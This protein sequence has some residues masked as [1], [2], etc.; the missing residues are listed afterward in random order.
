MLKRT[1]LFLFLSFTISGVF[2]QSGTL[3]GKILDKDNNNEP[4]PFANI[5]IL[6]N[7][8]VITGGMTDFDGKYTIKPIPAGV[9]DVKASYVGYQAKMIKGLRITAG[10]I[11]FQDFKLSAASE[12]LKEVEV[13]DYKVPL[14]SKDQTES[15]GTVT[16]EEISKMP[17][18]SAESVAS[19]VGGVYSED[20][21]VA[22]IRGSRSDATVYY[23]D[24]MKVRGTN[25]VPKSALEQVTVIT[26]G[27]PAKYG[28]ATGGVIS[29]TT[30]GPQK[31]MFGGAEFVTSHFLDNY[32][33][34]LGE[35]YLSGPMFSKK[36]KD[37]NDSTKTIKE[38]I[39]GYFVSANGMYFEDPNTSPLGY[40]KANDGVR[41]AYLN[42]PYTFGNNN[43]EGVGGFITTPTA[44]FYR[45]DDFHKIYTAENSAQ[46]RF[47]AQGKVDIKPSKAIN[48]TI[49]GTYDY[50]NQ[51]LFS[52]SNTAFNSSNNGQQIYSNWRVYGRLTHKLGN[53][54]YGKEED[55]KSASL[56]KNVYYTLQVDYNKIN[57]KRQDYN[58]QDDLFAYGHNGYYKTYKIKTYEFTDT[59]SGY[60]QG[61]WM[62][63]GFMDTLVTF[64]P[65]ED[66][67][68]VGKYTDYVY[69]LADEN[70]ADFIYMNKTFLEQFG[71]IMNGYSPNSV[72]GMWAS[73]GTVYNSYVKSDNQQ[74][75][76]TGAGYADVGDHEL[77]IGF[78]FEQRNDAYYGVS[79]R[80][81]W[82]LAEQNLNRHIEQLDLSN[83]IYSN[84]T[85][86]YNRLYNKQ[87]QSEFDI[88]FRN[89]L[90]DAGEYIDGK[91]VTATGTQWID[92]DTYRSDQ[93]KIDYFSPDELLNDGN[94]YVSY[95]GYDAHGNRISGNPTLYDFF[96][97][98]YTDALGNQRYKR[99]IAAFKPNYAAFY[100]QDKF[101]FNDLIFNIGLRVDRYDANQMVLKDMYL[102]HDAKTVGDIIN[103]GYVSRSE[104]PSAI[105]DDYIVYVNDFND[106]HSVSDIKG[107]RSGKNP[108]EVAWFDA[109]GNQIT[110]YKKIES[111]TG[112]APLLKDPGALNENRNVNYNAF[113]DYDPQYTWMP[114]ISFSF[115]ISDEALFFAH[116]DVLSQRPG[117]NNLD[118]LAYM[119]IDKQGN[120][121]I[122]NPNLRP[123]RT[124]D[125][126]VGFQQKLTN[127]SSLKLSGFYKEMR[128]MIQ[129]QKIAG[130]YPADYMTYT[131]I[132]FGTVKGITITY[133][134]RRTGNVSMKLS[135]TLQFANGTGS[136][137]ETGKA[138][139][140]TDQP[141]LRTT[142]P[143][144]FD[145][146]HAIQGVFDYRFG[147]GK[148]YNGPRWFGMDFFQNTGANFVFNFGTGTPYSRR[149]PNTNYLI[150][151]LNGS[152]KPS[153]FTVDLRLD[154]DI[155]LTFGKDDNKK[156]ANLNVYLQINN[157]FNTLNIR[158]VYSTTGNADDDGYL[159]AAKNQPV[160]N[161]QYDPQ[162]Y[163]DYYNMMLDSRYWM[164]YSPRT[165][166][167]GVL[168]N[169]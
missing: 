21:Q 10:K 74:F 108:S 129:T 142:M 9:Y 136:N 80:G 98:T 111:G 31:N 54:E 68:E 42:E 33:Y 106:F 26:G 128:D 75:R 140:Q 107:F 13:V 6:Q 49:G 28:D 64:K 38:P 127:S 168:F 167:L 162:S 123:S 43:G 58:H 144:D 35:A 104:I 14:I 71:A 149:D 100:I 52:L 73:P 119:Y 117:G 103:E 25:A 15:G 62:Q 122:N 12:I 169:F 155:P 2:A 141:N 143:L 131:N 158:N 126:E 5:S 90:H 163:R 88:N 27:L 115:P 44:D 7:G 150:G 39:V 147:S 159:T 92:L 109:N 55:E 93:L 79:P 18:R 112:L 66:N 59:L 82:V 4:I 161:S 118:P 24:G 152:R 30:K 110:D 78:E 16:S 17:G 130:A 157:L 86:R 69:R 133:D 156:H 102:L 72:Y 1:L 29:I 47:T 87:V 96:Y 132:D 125:Y 99:E 113:V 36:K 51:R 60:P 37:P 139:A 137:A 164:Y 166:R 65:T 124:I 160:I 153:T 61:V 63:N 57:N 77:Q 95:R 165:I 134:L 135:Y 121:V 41:D 50:A 114:R 85:V 81:L 19:T 11:T 8:K 146:R 67:P 32:N 45:K 20:G 116:Y 40:Y 120:N 154:K 48:V 148:M 53:N 34:N 145:R 76:F 22:S 46:K 56:F 89:A 3:K 91:L 23:I 101:A 151:S 94:S 138:L 105:G 84:D 83:P 70:N 97:D